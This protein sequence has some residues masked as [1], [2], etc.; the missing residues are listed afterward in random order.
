MMAKINDE[1][2][3]Y[4]GNET[5]GEDIIEADD[6]IQ[7][8]CYQSDN[9]QMFQKTVCF[10]NAFTSSLNIVRFFSLQQIACLRTLRN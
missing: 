6:S 3:N 9:F 4:S 2:F 5:V 10:K 8:K 1:I 7:M